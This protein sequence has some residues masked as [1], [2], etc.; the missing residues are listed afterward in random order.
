MHLLHRII[1]ATYSRST[2]HKLALDALCHLQS[3]DRDCWQR[4]FLK[5]HE[6]YLTGAKAPDTTFKDFQNHVLHVEQNNWG[7][8]IR[9]VRVWYD[10]LIE[11]LR[12]GKWK[13]AVYEAGVMSH[14]YVDPIQPFHT[15]Q[16]E[17]EN[18]IHRAA[19]WSITKSYDVLRHLV[20]EQHG[21]PRVDV[22]QGDDWLEQMVIAGAD[23]SHRHYDTLIR[24]YDFDRGV[25]KP[26][27]GLDRHCREMIAALLGYAAVGL[28]RILDRAFAEAAVTPPDVGLTAATFLATMEIPVQWVAK[29]IADAGER[30]EVLAIYDELQRTGK[31]EENL[32]EDDR[33]VREMVINETVIPYNRAKSSRSQQESRPAQNRP[34]SHEEPMCEVRAETS[35]RREQ[36]QTPRYQD[37]FC[38]QAKRERS[39]EATSSAPAL[40]FYLERSSDVENAPSI[41]PKTAERLR[42]IGVRTVADLLALDVESAARKLNVRHITSDTLRDWQA[43]ASLACRI[44]GLRGHDAQILVACGLRDAEDVARAGIDWLLKKTLDFAATT[45]GQ[46]VIRSGR[47]PDRDEIHDWIRC[48]EQARPLRAA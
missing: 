30:A 18:N 12:A 29:K 9:S 6:A 37:Q 40:R 38:S 42:R 26:Q 21:W 10:G 16:S 22:P 4:L 13:A 45:E 33:T 3:R 27:E 14:Y 41:G 11:S 7:G 23:L 2:H 32:P 31:V 1:F 15:G 8:A 35:A 34:L 5:Y 43:Q 20:E 48:A 24:R 25:K 28:A 47:A 19:E 46:R 17:A 44:P 39:D 36:G